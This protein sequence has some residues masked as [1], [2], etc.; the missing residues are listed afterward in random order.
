MKR[1]LLLFLFFSVSFSSVFGQVGGEDLPPPEPVAFVNVNV[2][3][4]TG[5]RVLEN[6][7]VLVRDGRIAQVGAADEVEV[8]EDA[9]PVDGEGR[10]L[11]P[12]WAEM[13]G[14]IPSPISEP[15]FTENVLFLYLANGVTT[16]R[17]MLGR[18]GQLAL[19]ERANSGQIYSP[20]LYLAGPPFTGNAVGSPGEARQMV[21]QQKYDG[22]DFLKVLEGMNREEYD[23]MA[24]TAREVEIPFAGHVPNGISVLHVIEQ[25][26]ATIDH[27]D[28]YVTYL[29]GAEGPVD[30]D[31]LQDVVQKTREAGVGIIPTMAVW[32]TLR[33]TPRLS[34]LTAVEGLQ[35]LPPQLVEDWTESHRNRRQD[36][37]FDEARAQ[38]VVD[39]RMRILEALHDG[40][41]QILFGTDAPQQFSVPG[42]S[43]HRE[44]KRMEEAGMTP[45]EIIA[46]ATR[47][48]GSYFEEKDDFG[49]VEEGQR[50]DLMLLEENPLDDLAH[51]SERT[52]V[53]V[54]GRWLPEEVIQDRLDQMAAS[55]EQ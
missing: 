30:E 24:E 25:G 44:V 36:P 7:T 45:Y 13:H 43:I 4:M 34:T 12:G 17:G 38:Q 5:E 50:A 32:E 21:R 27:I 20:T 16:V 15:E 28:G 39:S 8:P 48:V 23:A 19:R 29:N 33:G 2:L 42:Y 1:L 46:S 26:Q 3:P 53:M 11:L 49:T 22:W 51:L 40:G 18:E 54:R 55:Y 9:Q 52:G 31:E 14:H 10:Y 37:S 47:E 6:Q 35:Y 41:V